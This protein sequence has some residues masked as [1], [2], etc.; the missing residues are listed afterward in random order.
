MLI[1]KALICEGKKAGSC[2]EKSKK[3][4]RTEWGGWGQSELNLGGLSCFG[5][6]AGIM[7]VIWSCLQK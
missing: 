6:P 3:T 2:R 1:A 5:D 7:S 4:T